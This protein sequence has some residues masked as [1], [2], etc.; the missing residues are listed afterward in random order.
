MLTRSSFPKEFRNRVELAKSSKTNDA[1]LALRAL[2]DSFFILFRPV[3][4]VVTC[5]APRILDT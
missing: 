4:G 2:R 5:H 1:K 3:I